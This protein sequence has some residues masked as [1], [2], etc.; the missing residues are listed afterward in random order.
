MKELL[1]KSICN[2][3]QVSQEHLF[4]NVLERNYSRGYLA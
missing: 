3:T 1:F 4:V 2:Q